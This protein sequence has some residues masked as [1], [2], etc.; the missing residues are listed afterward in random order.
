MTIFVKFLGS[1]ANSVIVFAHK[2]TGFI[3]S[4]DR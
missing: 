4:G 3:A 1:L 2:N